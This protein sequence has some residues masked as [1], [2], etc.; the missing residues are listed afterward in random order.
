METDECSNMRVCA[1][2]LVQQGVHGDHN[3]IAAESQAAEAVL[4]MGMASV[5]GRAAVYA[6]PLVYNAAW[7]EKEKSRF[8]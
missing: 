6:N 2:Q 8:L 5:G 3:S 4:E 7:K 1:V